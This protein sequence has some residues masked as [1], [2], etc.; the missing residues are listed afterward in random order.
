MLLN[1]S[2]YSSF[3]WALASVRAVFGI[4]SGP[5]ALCLCKFFYDFVKFFHCEGYGDIVF[6]GVSQLFN[7]VYDSLLWCSYWGSPGLAWYR[8]S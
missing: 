6:C 1:T 3:V 2:K 7:F 8:F 4:L 5:G